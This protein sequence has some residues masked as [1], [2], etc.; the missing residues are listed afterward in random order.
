MK[1][2]LTSLLLLCFFYNATLGQDTTITVELSS[3]LSMGL[4]Y[5]TENYNTQRAEGL[6][7]KNPVTPKEYVQFLISQ[8]ATDGLAQLDHTIVNPLLP[9]L[10]LLDAETLQKV[11]VTISSDIVKQRLMQR[12]KD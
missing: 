12:L 3:D 8:R 10:R 5:A 6:S 1:V 9:S 4:I 7:P 11:L 2:F